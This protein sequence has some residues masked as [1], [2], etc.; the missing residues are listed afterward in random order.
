MGFDYIILGA[1]Q[2]GTAAAYDL[3]RW[4]EADRVVLADVDLERAK[5]S[6][7]RVNRLL[8][9]PI[10]QAKQLDVNDSDALIE[11]LR[12]MDCCLSAVPYHF[13]V[14]I[15]EAAATAETNFCDLGGNT[16]IVQR[17]L[18]L[19]K[20]ARRAGVALVP[21]CGL[22]P[23]MANT[24]AVYGMERIAHLGGRAQ[25][26]HI[27]CGGL[28][29]KPRPPLGYKLVFSIEG[30]T[31][32]YSGKAYI[33][34]NGKVAAVDTLTEPEELTFASLGQLEAV[35]TSGGTS[36]CPWTFE[37]RLRCYEYKTLRYPGHF[38]KIRTLAD[39]GLLD[40]DPVDVNGQ[41]VVPRALFHRAAAPRL[42]FPNDRDLV[43]LRVRC[44]G[45]RDG[46]AITVQYDLLD[47]HDESMGFTAMERLTGFPAAIVAS[48]LAH[49]RVEPGAVP[50]EQAIPAEPFMQELLRRSICPI[51]S[52]TRILDA[53]EPT[54]AGEADE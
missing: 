43:V 30:L 37:G 47:Y 34:R 10:T 11:R 45:E 21:D 15:A 31:N 9:R 54:L 49:G 17:E 25:D 26:V 23:G 18:A 29:Q 16:E 40:L 5:S 32:E 12:G 2:Q 36:T 41:R 42:N 46:E 24:I 33:L 6:A 19:T 7:K 3:A 13:N 22:A 28:P 27:Y 48:M 51:E 38:E 4:G 39:L 35:I 8:D 53:N 20:Q 44:A 52:V 1:G 50:L 14:K